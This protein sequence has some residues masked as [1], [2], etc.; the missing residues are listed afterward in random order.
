M[1]IVKIF[2]TNNFFL[3]LLYSIAGDLSMGT[4]RK[5]VKSLRIFRLGGS[6][7][8]V[9]LVTRARHKEKAAYFPFPAEK[10]PGKNKNPGKTGVFEAAVF[11]TANHGA[12]CRNK[13]EPRGKEE[14]DRE[15]SP[16]CFST[17]STYALENLSVVTV[18]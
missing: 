15:A 5:N 16:T 13:H 17:S 7:E 14:A 2:I 11:F 1:T 8:K 9:C 3:F 10:V 4:R 18:S 12:E 6:A